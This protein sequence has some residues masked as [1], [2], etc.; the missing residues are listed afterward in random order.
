MTAASSPDRPP[1]SRRGE[2]NFVAGQI[3]ALGL[4]VLA[5]AARVWLGSQFNGVLVYALYYPVVLAAALH[6]G[7]PAG[8]TAL[9]AST[10]AGRLLFAP[11]PTALDLVGVINLALFVAAGG[12]LVFAGAYARAQMRRAARA[13]AEL[14]L[15]EGRYRLLFDSMSE[16]FA[17]CEAIRDSEG[18]IVDYRMQEVNPALQ[19]MLGRGPELVGMRLSEIRP[20]TD[21]SA[22][23]VFE[24]VLETRTAETFE[25]HMPSMDRWFEIHVTPV[26]ENQWAQFFIDVTERK[27]VEARQAELFDE[28]NHRVKNNLMM[29]SGLL[30]VQARGSRQPAVREE[31]LKAVAR[32]QSIADVHASLYRN[33]GKGDVEFGD[34]LEDLC[35]G[36]SQVVADEGRLR[37][38]VEC[39]PAIVRLDQAVPLGLIVNELVTNAAKHAYPP[40]R[41]GAIR[42]RLVKADGGLSL[43]VGDDGH[44]LPDG[45]ETKPGGLGMKLVQSLVQQ[46]GG[47]L[48][49]RRGPGAAFEIRL[50]QPAPA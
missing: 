41:D 44:G 34:Y 17:L 43:S 40:P 6:A 23:A 15:R 14:S 28:L 37:L 46:V 32:V 47:E 29:V 30:S 11:D 48:E 42:V 33:S 19:G 24:R 49:I 22:L 12:S 13:Q 35:K 20:E 26:R 36:L 5:T 2:P 4:V 8:I 10:L 3:V 21:R 39:E 18:R 31:L 38:E 25:F 50:P 9:T 27:R 16:A 1:G 45:A 7:W